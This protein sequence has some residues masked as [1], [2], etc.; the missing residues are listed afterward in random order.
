MF[1]VVFKGLRVNANSKL[2][3][4]EFW[5]TF[6]CYDWEMKCD[7]KMKWNH[8]FSKIPI[9][10]QLAKKGKYERKSTVPIFLVE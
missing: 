7:H 4:V 6:D 2:I 10:H 9:L 5:K 3:S 1:F 8:G